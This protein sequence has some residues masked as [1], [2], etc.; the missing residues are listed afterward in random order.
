[1]YDLAL[2]GGTL[3]D[4]TGKSGREADVAVIGG[5]I[6]ATGAVGEAPA[7]RRLDVSGLAVAPGFV[8]MHTHADVAVL[9][10]PLA[11][12][13]VRQG[14]TTIAT[15]QCGFS[16]FPVRRG[17]Y[18]E[19]QSV[20]P[21]V[22]VPVECVWADTRGYLDVL[23]EVEPGINVVPF[24]GHGTLRAYGVGLENRQ[25]CESELCEL[26]EACHEALLQGAAGISFGLTF[27]PSAMADT[28]E[29]IRLCKIGAEFDRLCS[30]HI[31]GADNRLLD[32]IQEAIEVADRS[33]ARVE[34]AHLKASG[35][36]NWGQVE[37]ALQLIEAAASRGLRIG[38]DV[39]PYTAA[40]TH[41]AAL[42][43]L[44]VSAGGWAEMKH[45]LQDPAI[46]R[47]LSDQHRDLLGGRDSERITIIS[48]ASQLNQWLVGK[49]IAEI[50][51]H[52]G[53]AD[54]DCMVELIVE[55]ENH[56]EV[57]VF[58]MCE[59]DMNAALVHPL[60]AV[61]SDALA[62]ASSEE[63]ATG[64]THP[65]AFGTFPRVLG[66]YVRE[67]SLLSLEEAI[68]KMT[69]LPAQRLGLADRGRIAENMAADLVVFDPATVID[70]AT[71]QQPC[72]YPDGIEHVIINGE[73]VV[74]H[75]QHTGRQP[76]HVI[77]LTTTAHQ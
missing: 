29:L 70:R 18:A 17:S 10:D 8:D 36:A 54:I 7:V 22:F 27:F 20:M 3:I 37:A 55:E 34:V 12:N 68:R 32:A 74:E 41:L 57:I 24:V 72:Q 44:W 53:V 71:F 52:R 2:C 1:M 69:S 47:T 48:V 61:A 35:R 66:R 73:I 56:V 21:C 15:G 75:G 33:G 9:R 65:R 13:F 26:E 50:A 49:T 5:Y 51:R 38:F 60:G 43:P 64:G 77:T 16:A 59:Q 30:M 19:L 25:L 63:S 28:S 42:L 45:R 58:S 31:R 39:Y 46:R 67:K 62:L 14:V 11:H 6:A 4:G 40:S 76:G 23:Q